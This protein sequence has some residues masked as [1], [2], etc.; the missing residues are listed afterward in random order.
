MIDVLYP[1]VLV[2]VV[3]RRG[4]VFSCL[5]S[6]IDTLDRFY[7]LGPSDWYRSEHLLGGS[8]GKTQIS[9][10]LLVGGNY[11]PDGTWWI[12]L[13]GSCHIRSGP[14]IHWGRM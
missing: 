8:H 4:G 6:K 3:F 9:V 7:R 10:A 2:I 11:Q 14:Q 13:L 5:F 1:V 12:V